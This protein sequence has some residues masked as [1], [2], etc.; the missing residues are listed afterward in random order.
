V[1]S[2]RTAAIEGVT[3]GDPL[4]TLVDHDDN[5]RKVTDPELAAPDG[6]SWERSDPEIM[7]SSDEAGRIDTIVFSEHCRYRGVDLI[8]ADLATLERVAG[9]GWVARSQWTYEYEDWCD[10]MMLNGVV[11]GVTLKNW[12]PD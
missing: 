11:V 10:V 1:E 7:V 8:G 6:E 4:A 3:L 12:D 5:W 2:M 9:P